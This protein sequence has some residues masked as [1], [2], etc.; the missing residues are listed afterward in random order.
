MTEQVAFNVHAELYEDETGDLA[1][2]LEGDYVYRIPPPDGTARFQEDA[3]RALQ[4]GQFP[5]GWQ[6][7]PARELIYGHGWHRVSLMGYLDGDESRL[8]LELEVEADRLG[9]QARRYL[10]DILH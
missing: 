5:A 8:A 3:A 9:P 6:E 2:L 4:T 7:M 1:V 10:R